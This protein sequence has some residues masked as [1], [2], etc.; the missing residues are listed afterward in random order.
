[1]PLE[2][3][4]KSDNPYGLIAEVCHHRGELTLELPSVQP[5]VGAQESTYVNS[6]LPLMLY[7]AR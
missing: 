2:H 4:Q 1:M 6:V 5:N 3:K 7:T